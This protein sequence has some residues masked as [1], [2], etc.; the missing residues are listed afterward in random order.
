MLW[1][2]RKLLALEKTWPPIFLHRPVAEPFL[3]LVPALVLLLLLLL[4][5]LRVLHVLPVLSL[6]MFAH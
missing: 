3:A 1:F 6:R 2:S 4:L 5:L